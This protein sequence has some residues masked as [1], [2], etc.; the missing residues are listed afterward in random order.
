MLLEIKVIY[1]ELVL[2]VS[3]DILQFLSSE[4][5]FNTVRF[6][7]YAIHRLWLSF[8]RTMCIQVATLAPKLDKISLLFLYDEYYS[9][10]TEVNV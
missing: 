4:I 1:V 5:E 7:N 3:G 9:T 8:R 6:I 10:T 2:F